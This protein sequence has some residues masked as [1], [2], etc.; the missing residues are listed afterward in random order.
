MRELVEKPANYRVYFKSLKDK[1]ISLRD[2]SIAKK[3]M[4]DTAIK[5]LYEEIESKSEYI[6]NNYNINLYDYS[7]YKNNEYSKGTF[8][9]MAKEEFANKK[10]NYTVVSDL[11]AIYDLAF[12][13]KE[14]HDINKYITFCDKIINLPLKEYVEI[15]R[16]FYTEVQT[17]LIL[18]GNGY[19]F[20]GLLG[21]MCFVRQQLRTKGAC[22]D[23][24]ATK[25]KRKELKDN[26]ERVFNKVEYEW[27]KAHDVDYE[28]SDPRVYLPHT[29]YYCSLRLYGT[30]LPNGTKYKLVSSDFR[31]AS[32]RGMSNDDLIDKCNR[33][34]NEICKLPVDIKTKLTLCMKVDDTLYLN[35][36]RYE[37]KKPNIIAK[38]SR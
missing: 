13:Q 18:E 21:W 17:K 10:N 15:L 9:K 1:Y 14:V 8:L 30:K 25:K 32:I 38:A 22:I 4:L 12:K 2:N 31:Q 3:E 6:K 26:G 20:E 34:V 29:E 11:Y 36:N 35:Y 33:D 37:N 16:T 7:E 24:Q 19:A 27:C 28:A 23:W 5:D